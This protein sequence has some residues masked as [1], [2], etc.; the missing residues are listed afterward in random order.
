MRTVAISRSSPVYAI[1]APDSELVSFATGSRASA[2]TCAQLVGRPAIVDHTLAARRREQHDAC[3]LDVGH[4]VDQCLRLRLALGFA[5]RDPPLSRRNLVPVLGGKV[6]VQ[7]HAA[8]IARRA[9]RAAVGIGVAN[10][11][12]GRAREAARE[13]GPGVAASSPVSTDAPGSS[14]AS[15]PMTNT[16]RSPCPNCANSM[17]RPSFDRAMP[18]SVA[19]RRTVARSRRLNS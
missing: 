15:G 4:Q 3:R 19:W 5:T 12:D 10:D 16:C 1:S 7:E 13:T 14:P 2:P 8:A 9:P 18:P 17:R 6:P 11:R